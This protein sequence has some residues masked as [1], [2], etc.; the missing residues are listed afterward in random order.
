MDSALPPPPGDPPPPDSADECIPPK[1]RGTWHSDQQPVTFIPPKKRRIWRNVQHPEVSNIDWISAMPDDILVKILSLVTI[2]EAAMTD[3]LSSRWRHLWENIHQLSLKARAFGM[4]VLPNSNYLE[5]P[6]LWNSEATKFVHKVNELLRHH[7]GSGV[8]EFKVQF[9]LT[10]AHAPDINR[11][12]VFAV[13]SGA[14]SLKLLLSLCDVHVVLN[15]MSSCSALRLMG[16]RKCHQL[17]NLRASHPQLLCMEVYDCKSL[18]SISIHAEKLVDFSYK[19]HKVDVQYEYAPVVHSLSAHFVKKN[20]CPLECIGAHFKLRS[21][22]LQFPSRL[23]VPCVLQKGE[24]FAGLKEI[25][26]CL[27]T[28]WKER[29]HSVAYL[30]KAAPV[31]ETFKLEVYGNL[32]PVSKLKVKWPKNCILRVL[33]TVKLGGFSGEAELLRLLFF[34]LRRSPMLKDLLID[35]HPCHYVG[36]GRWKREKSEDAMRCY[37]ARGVALKHLPPKIPSTV[38]LS[39]M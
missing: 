30:L 23:Q 37:Y 34:L 13:T 10:S 20:E 12:V 8:Q 16:L 5:N 9:P 21:L 15:I 39:V 32:Q 4:Q 33:H 35:P 24:R 7:N 25:V 3:C 38:K 17:I 2:R 19:G 36:F 28:S 31:V 26:L 27:L 18:I 1:K 11:W 29:I 22:T 14:K 6:D